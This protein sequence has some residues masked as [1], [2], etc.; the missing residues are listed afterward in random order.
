MDIYTILHVALLHD[1]LMGGQQVPIGTIF[2]S[3][4][5]WQNSFAQQFGL[6][7][8]RVSYLPV[9]KNLYYQKRTEPIRIVDYNVQ[10]Q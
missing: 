9:T 4:T 6:S 3:S 5:N 1:S 7:G 8:V 10:V 2:M